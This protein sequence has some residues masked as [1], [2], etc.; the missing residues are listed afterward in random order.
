[1]LKRNLIKRI[2]SDMDYSFCRLNDRL[3]KR[4]LCDLNLILPVTSRFKELV[5]KEQKEAYLKAIR[6]QI[7]MVLIEEILEFSNGYYNF[8]KVEKINPVAISIIDFFQ[9]LS[10]CLSIPDTELTIKKKIELF[11]S[12]QLK[13]KKEISNN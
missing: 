7:K 12:F 13:S 4:V 2:L 9:T 5:L 10:E 6:L 8:G 11:E 1:M 3:L